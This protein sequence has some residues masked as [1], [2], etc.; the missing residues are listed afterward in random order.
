MEDT[1]GK[2]VAILICAVQMF[3]I[4]AYWYSQS[5]DRMEQSYIMAEITHNVDNFRN[6]GMISAKQYED[7]KG[8][9]YSLAG[10][11]DISIIHYVS[12]TQENADSYFDTVWYEDYVEEC[13]ETDG[14]YYLGKNDYINI[15]VK[16]KNEEVKY[17]YGGSVKN[18]AY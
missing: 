8:R 12:S 13:M 4:P 3:I 18:E 14:V 11:Y 7:M 6:T 10:S 15:T 5:V 9:I 1:F 16:S 17:C 2:V